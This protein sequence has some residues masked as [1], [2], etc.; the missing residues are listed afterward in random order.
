MIVCG[1]FLLLGVTRMI[2]VAE[3]R[4][5]NILDQ[6]IQSEIYELNRH[7]LLLAQRLAQVSLPE[8]SMRFGLTIAEA[9]YLAGASM[10]D[11]RQLAFENLTIMRPRLNLLEIGAGNAMTRTRALMAALSPAGEQS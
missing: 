10:S 7:W 8:A 9:T 6:L 3:S 4:D 11:I 1:L 2:G 5:Q